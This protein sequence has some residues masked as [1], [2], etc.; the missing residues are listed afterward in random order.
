MIHTA[1][2]V[3][4][5]NVMRDAVGLTGSDYNF[6]CDAPPPGRFET[7]DPSISSNSSNLVSLTCMYGPVPLLQS[8]QGRRLWSAICGL[9]DRQQRSCIKGRKRVEPGVELTTW[10]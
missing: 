4:N 7:K 10:L 9:E 6:G 2:Q 3:M 8:G 5:V 1:V